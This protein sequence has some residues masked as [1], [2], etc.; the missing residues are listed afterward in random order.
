MILVGYLAI[1][2]KCL[3]LEEKN[4]KE[5]QKEIQ[6][7]KAKVKEKE[8]QKGKKIQNTKENIKIFSLLLYIQCYLPL[9]F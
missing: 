4:A 2:A 6:K 5:R 3:V 7:A 8:I 9:L 1:I